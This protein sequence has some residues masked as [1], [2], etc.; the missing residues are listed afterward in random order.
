MKITTKV[1]LMWDEQAQRYVADPSTWEGYEYDGPVAHCKGD[2]TAKQAEQQQAAFNANLMNIFNQQFVKQNE[3]RDFLAGK[4]KP[5]IDNPTGYSPEALTAMRTGATESIAGQ[6]ANA[7]KALQAKLATRGGDAATLPNGVNDQLLATLSEGQ[8]SD[9]AGAQNSI[10][11]ADE[12]LKQQNY[13]AAINALSGQEAM[14]NPLGYAGA[15]NS[16]G[17]TVA[18]LANAFQNSTQSGWFNALAGGIG[19]GLTSWATGG[20]KNPFGKGGCWIARAV[21]GEDSLTAEMIRVRLWNRASKS[22]PYRLLMSLY[23]KFGERIAKRVKTSPT[24]QSSFGF[25]FERFL[26]ME[27]GY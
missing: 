19:G 15:V 20:F 26:Q 11:L 25:L 22:T 3:Y 5:M 9:T 14:V 18:N 1:C 23:M 7:Q 21:Y 27:T 24:L 17:D 13:W 6:Y 4:L 10:T 2:D 8:A 16:G 12:N